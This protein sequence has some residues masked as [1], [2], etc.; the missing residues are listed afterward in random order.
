MSELRSSL[1]ARLAI[2]EG[3]INQAWRDRDTRAEIAHKA[4]AAVEA[5]DA[6]ISDLLDQQDNIRQQI[7]ELETK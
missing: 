3:K 7:K 5:W 2:Q 1:V 4:L 6:T